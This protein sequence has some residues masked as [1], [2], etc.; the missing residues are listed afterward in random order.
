MFTF[1]QDMQLA[2]YISLIQDSGLVCCYNLF[3][4]HLHVLGEKQKIRY[5]LNSYF[6][7]KTQYSGQEF[8]SN[9]HNVTCCG[10]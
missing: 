4:L 9:N 7:Q 5:V 2:L 6:A 10:M 1:L 3:C 8:Q